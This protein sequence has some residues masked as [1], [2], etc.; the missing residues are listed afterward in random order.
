MMG[1]GRSEH[2][3]KQ[4]TES[5]RLQGRRSAFLICAASVMLEAVM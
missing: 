2:L 4:V 3:R 5:R 1:Q